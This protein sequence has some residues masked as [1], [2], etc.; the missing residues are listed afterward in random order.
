MC[1]LKER[2]TK[3]AEEEEEEAVDVETAG[4]KLS[5]L[6]NDGRMRQINLCLVGKAYIWETFSIQKKE[7]NVLSIY[8]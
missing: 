1:T 4:I 2:N 5:S 6:T 7:H 3:T 8:G